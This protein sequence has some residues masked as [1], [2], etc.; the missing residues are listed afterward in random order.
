MKIRELNI[1]KIKKGD[2]LSLFNENKD[3][4]QG[5]IGP[6]EQHLRYLGNN[7]FEVLKSTRSLEKGMII[8]SYLEKWKIGDQLEF[9]VKKAGNIHE[10]DL[11][12]KVLKFKM[13]PA[14]EIDLNNFNH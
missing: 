10:K 7:E 12:G 5:S 11:Q 1:T 3:P 6:S 2:V 13:R 8:I 9:V 14:R 4:V